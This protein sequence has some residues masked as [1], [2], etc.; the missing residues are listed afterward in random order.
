MGGEWGRGVGGL[1]FRVHFFSVNESTCSLL[2][3][4]LEHI[5][6]LLILL[7]IAGPPYK[8]LFYALDALF[9]LGHG[10]HQTKFIF[11]LLNHLKFYY[12]NF[13]FYL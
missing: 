7:N 12:V 10:I 5:I 1:G 13:P 2:C 9:F 11:P 6:W 4:L 8:G 3:P